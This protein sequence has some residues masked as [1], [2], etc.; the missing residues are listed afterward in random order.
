RQLSRQLSAAVALRILLL[1]VLAGMLR[2]VTAGAHQLLPILERN[3]L[4]AALQAAVGLIALPVFAYMV[5]DCVKRRAT[6][7]A[8]GIL[9]FASVFAYISELCALYL[10]AEIL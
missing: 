2:G 5:R 10:L 1:L 6:Q 3:W 8:T 9:Y 7:A 4:V